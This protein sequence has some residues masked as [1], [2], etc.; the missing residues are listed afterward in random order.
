MPSTGSA[1]GAAAADLGWIIGPPLRA[2]F[3]KLLGG[4]HAT[5]AAIARY[6]EH[7]CNRGMYDA[8]VYAGIPE[9][10]DRLQAACWRLL[11]ATA[12]PHDFCPSDPGALCPRA[13]L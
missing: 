4:T 9:A 6:R 8:V 13:P 2:S 10:L 7:Y 3:P 11:V 1:P 12:K 5:E